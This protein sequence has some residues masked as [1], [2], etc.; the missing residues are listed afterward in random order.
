T[1]FAG[2]RPSPPRNVGFLESTLGERPK[3]ETRVDNALAGHPL[4]RLLFHWVLRHARTRVRDRENLRF[5]R[6]RLFGHVRRVFVE[7]GRRL[8]AEG[9]LAEARDIFFLEID[10]LLGFLAGSAT[11]TK[12]KPLVL[13]R[14]AQFAE[15]RNGEAPPGRFTTR[16]VV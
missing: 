14:Q 12:L 6:T 5:E 9:H 8:H 15:Y 13:L 3:A 16:G 7:L 2:T 1:L 11:T 10:E 4:R